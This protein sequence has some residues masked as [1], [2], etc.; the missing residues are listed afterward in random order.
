VLMEVAALPVGTL[1]R[2]CALCLILLVAA[3]GPACARVPVDLSPPP[4][5]EIPPVI[6]APADTDAD[7]NRVDD[8][9]EARL[10]EA[11]STTPQ[12]LDAQ[13]RPSAGE[14][15]A[16]QL[17]FSRQITQSQIDA[18]MALGGTID[19]I[20]RSVSYGWNGRI[21]L[22]AAVRL[23]EIMG[24]SLVGV[25]SETKL[26][27]CMDRGTQRGRVRNLWE[28]GYTGDS[29]TVIAVVDSGVDG[30]HTDLSDNLEYWRDYSTASQS[31]PVDTHG[32]GTFMTSIACGSGASAG[33]DPHIIYFTNGGDM[34]GVPEG[35]CY[36]FPFVFPAALSGSTVTFETEAVCRESN[37]SGILGLLARPSGSDSNAAP[38]GNIYQGRLPLFVSNSFTA[39]VDRVYFPVLL[40]NSGASGF[41][42]F[43]QLNTVSFAGVDRHPVLAGVARAC[44]WAGGKVADANGDM[45]SSAVNAAIDDMVAQ[46]RVH[47]IKVI[48]LSLGGVI[49]TTMRAKVNTAVNNG[50]VVVAAAGNDH[51]GPGTGVVTDPG[52]AGLAITVGASNDVNQLTDFSGIGFSSPQASEDFKPDI[53][54]P[55]GSFYYGNMLGADTNDCDAGSPLFGDQRSND[56]TG[57]MGTSMSTAFV[58]GAAG[59]VIQALESAGVTWDH[60]SSATALLVK[61][62]LC[63]TATETN[64][65]REVY[66]G[67]NPTLGRSANP[68][69]KFEG[70]GILNPDAAVE[71][72]TTVISGSS[73]WSA[74]TPGGS[75]DK[76]AWGRKI[77]MMP[78][79]SISLTLESPSRGDFDIYLYSGTP[80]PKGNPVILKASCLAGTSIEDAIEYESGVSGEAYLVVKRVSGYGQWTITGSAVATTSSTQTAHRAA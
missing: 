63:A 54:A 23:P 61:M 32:H 36:V 11:M 30:S 46:R 18:F 14:T 55:G 19:Y 7:S 31:S 69:D 60:D 41:S 6:I 33:V 52:R 35:A 47:N 28:S 26:T 49:D 73:P 56:Y 24:D 58:S 22:A 79:T 64:S 40:E 20:F 16:V 4:E 34:T 59:L 21:P 3:L 70:Y 38:L 50:V 39:S 45:T 62:L 80:D 13:P 17:V 15:V 9:L 72:V 44:K 48:N 1:K 25:V 42:H 71:A 51:Y 67:D 53:L 2:L 12:A 27:F 37:G 29:N 8:V 65:I 66:S 68:K 43:A 76:R 78:G 57:G 10:A 77:E 74:T 75:I 5:P